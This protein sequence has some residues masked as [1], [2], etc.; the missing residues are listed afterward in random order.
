[1]SA[2]G[3]LGMSGLVVGEQG[4]VDDLDDLPL[5]GTEGL[6]GGFAFGEFAVVV[7]TAGTG[8]ADLG[9]RDQVDRGVGGPVAATVDPLA[10]VGAAGGV[11]GG[12][13]GG[14][15]VVVGA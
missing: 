11:D 8:P 6:V 1:M 10:E 2:G 14:A 9:A 12:G 4:S 15:G 7:G 13:A 5:E 3:G